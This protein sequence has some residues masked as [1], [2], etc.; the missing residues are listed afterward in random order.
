VAVNYEQIVDAL[1][2]QRESITAER[3]RAANPWPATAA[4]AKFNFLLQSLSEEQRLLLSE[5]LQSE[6]DSGIHDALAALS[7]LMNLEGLRFSAHGQELPHE[8]Y[9][10]EI[11]FDWLARSAGDPWPRG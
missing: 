7:E 11:H 6:R 2:E 8:P 5:L 3:F 1:V 10:T 4:K 9:G